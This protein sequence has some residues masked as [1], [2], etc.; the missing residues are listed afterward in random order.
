MEAIMSEEYKYLI[1]FYFHNSNSD[2]G[3]QSIDMDFYHRINPDD[4]VDIEDRIETM[5]GYSTVK[6]MSFSLYVEEKAN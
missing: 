6:L 3:F 5:F 2:F 1:A 4:K